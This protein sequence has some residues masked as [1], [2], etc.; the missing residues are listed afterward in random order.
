L[1]LALL[2]GLV[3]LAC[4]PLN[5]I[6]SAQG[7]L[8]AA[9]PAFGGGWGP[10]SLALMLAP[11]AAMPLLLLLQ[12]RLW[13][14]GA[15]SGL[16]Q[17]LVC[18]EEPERSAALI[19]AGPTL[20]RLCLWAMATLA[21]LFLLSGGAGGGDGEDL[22]VALLQ[23]KGGDL[24][25]APLL[26]ARLLGPALALGA[27]VPGG[28]IDP[29]LSLGAVVGRALG[30]GFGIGPLGLSLGMAACLAGATQLPLL[31]L[32]FSL[33]LAGDQQLLP[34]LLLAAVLGAYV[35]R[36]LIARPLY[37]QL[38]ADLRQQLSGPA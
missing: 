15:G 1:Q 16:P 30:D 9:L 19:G 34:G 33:R 31:S 14:A 17:T 13:P 4:W 20:E 36:L 6:D 32:V 21:L 18:L 23:P 24:V 11:L 10:T 35:G 25:G 3:G 5:L 7:R 8:L 28:L 26:L 2:G 37:H 27:G 12:S 29:A 38:A 22:M